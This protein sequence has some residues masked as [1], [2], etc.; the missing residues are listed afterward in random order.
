MK[1]SKKKEIIKA[2]EMVMQK[3]SGEVK[4][5]CSIDTF[6]FYAVFTFLH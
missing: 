1:M 5:L 3:I 2:M 6:S 4:E